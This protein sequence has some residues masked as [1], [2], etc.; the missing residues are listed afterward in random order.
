MGK[1]G[2]LLGQSLQPCSP[3]EGC[4]RFPAAP[5]RPWLPDSFPNCGSL[6]ALS[7]QWRWPGFLR[8]VSQL[9]QETQSGAAL[10]RGLL[11]PS[12]ALAARWAFLRPGE[13]GGLGGL[14]A[15]LG[16]SRGRA[17]GSLGP[18]RRLRGA[19]GR[20]SRG[21]PHPAQAPCLTFGSLSHTALPLVEQ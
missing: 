1:E 11:P 16:R 15:Q 12:L 13:H 3:A 4:P 5:F 19:A 9:G 17:R 18:R 8:E 21:A 7:C 10:S 20:G 6:T 14:G 2:V